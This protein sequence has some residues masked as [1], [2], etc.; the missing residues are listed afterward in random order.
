MEGTKEILPQLNT[1]DDI[2]RKIYT[3]RGEQVMLDSDLAEIYGYETK[4]FNRQVR[5]NIEKFDEEDFMFKLTEEEFQ[6]LRCKN[7]TS[8]W[9]GKRYLPY[10]FTE[11]GI[12]MLM[13]VLKGELDVKQSKML[14]KLFKD[15]RQYL[16]ENAIV[17][18]RLDRLEIRQFETDRKFEAIFKKLEAIFKKLE[19][20]RAKKAV[21]FFKGQL[22]DTF[23]C[24]ADITASAE[25]EIILI[26]GY[27][28]TATLDLLSKKKEKVC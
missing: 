9:G 20:P 19:E 5:N 27:T 24:I 21:L 28:D 17:F 14:V 2:R 4:N 12:Y 22:F 13:T 8:S 23:S 10:V 7:F 3:I 16:Y 25:K 6:N 26:D 1:S 18:N 11:Q 15:I